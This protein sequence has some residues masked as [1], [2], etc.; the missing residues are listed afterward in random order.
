MKILVVGGTFD[1]SGG[2]PSGVV[3]KVISAL[4]NETTEVTAYNGGD[5]D[6]LSDYLNQTPNYD[7]VFWWANVPNDLPKV[8]NVKEIA[9]KVML[10]TSK[11]NDNFKYTTM[12]VVQRALGAK[13]NLIFEFR[14]AS[15]S[16]YF[17]KKAKY[18]IRV[19]DPLGNEW[20]DTTDIESAVSK[21]VER[22]HY[23]KSVTRKPSIPTDIDKRLVFESC[24][25]SDKTVKVPEEE[26]FVSVVKK[27]AESFHEIL[28]PGP[29]V[30][31]FLG[32]C[33]MRPKST[34]CAKGFPS[35]RKDGYVFVSQRNVDK[36]YLTL[37]NFVPTYLENGEVYY[38]GEKKPSVDTPV[39]LRLYEL[40]PNINYM[41]HA[42]VYADEGKATGFPV[43]CGAIEEVDEVVK[44]IKENYG[45]LNENRY[46]LNL[47][48]HGCLLM[49]N[50]VNDIENIRF[51]GRP[52]PEIMHITPPDKIKKEEMDR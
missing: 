32:N 14:T 41:I 40:L 25:P 30:K 18:N 2:K 10:V 51:H 3:D 24:Y 11:R 4:S 19:L 36:E 15:Y 17:N 46:V 33:S 45:S 8:R 39:Q 7:I 13:A 49:G 22:L 20:A 26:H 43:P 16:G 31:R 34:R 5:Y 21:A 23:L 44:A 52:M 35:F 28:N 37:E 42:H 1:K 12:E 47:K 48:G 6:K 50:T 9:P 38:C 29:D 27:Y